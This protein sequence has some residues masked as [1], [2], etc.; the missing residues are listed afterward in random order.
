MTIYEIDQAL[1]DLVDPETGELKDLEAFESLQME[2]DKKVENMAL[3]YKDLTAQAAAIKSEIATLTER[4]Q[5][6]ERKASRL[7]D[8]IGIV[9]N[10]AK[11]QT[12]RC[13]VSYRASKSLSVDDADRVIRWAQETGNNQ[14]I[15]RKDPE[16]NAKEV[17]ALIDAGLAIPG[18]HIEEKKN[19][20]VK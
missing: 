11:F 18:A 2:R 5:A 3:W 17:K 20:G 6:A 10:G 9:L 14:C 15:R 19:V 7:L 1:L 8:Y 12:A 4:K 16:I 13:S